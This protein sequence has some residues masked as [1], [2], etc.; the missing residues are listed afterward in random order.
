MPLPVVWSHALFH[1]RPSSVQPA[2]VASCKSK[3][4][5]ATNKHKSLAAQR[6]RKHCRRSIVRFADL[7]I[8]YRIQKDAIF[9]EWKRDAF[10][11]C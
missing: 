10:N 11:S 1:L 9:T 5:V 8:R 7:R 3:G 6:R 4:A 2:A